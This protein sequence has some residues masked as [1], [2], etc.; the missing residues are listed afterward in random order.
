MAGPHSAAELNLIMQRFPYMTNPQALYT[1]FTTGRQNNTVNDAA[2]SAVPN[3]TRGQIVQ[4]P[5]R[6]NG[7]HTPSLR[8]AVRGPGQLLGPFHVDTHGYS[9]VWSNDISDVAIRARR[10]EDADEDTA[11]EATK[12]SKGWTNGLPPGASDADAFDFAT[13]TRREQAREARIYE[14]SLTKRGAG[15][16][17][18]T[19]DETWHGATTVRGGKLSVVGSHESPIDVSGEGLGVRDLGAADGG[20]SGASAAE[21]ERQRPALDVGAQIA[22]FELPLGEHVEAVGL[23]PPAEALALLSR[24]GGDEPG[25]DRLPGAVL[26]E[27]DVAGEQPLRRGAVTA[28]ERLGVGRPRLDDLDH[29]GTRVGGCRTS[30]Q[31][32]RD[33]RCDEQRQ[34]DDGTL[35]EQPEAHTDLGKAHRYPLLKRCAARPSPG[36]RRRRRRAE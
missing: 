29:V 31:H 12:V 35:R 4:V 18:L 11:W 15:T 22:G 10:Q 2:G 27:V 9:D 32:A 21:A 30:G 6:R 1:M 34:Q 23:H 16:L 17:F 8:E 26:A 33:R 24:C 14:G 28:P 25:V 19:G 36:P 5:D 3:P 7:W 13:G 20:G